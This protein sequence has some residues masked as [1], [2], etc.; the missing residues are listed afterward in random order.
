GDG[1]GALGLGGE[2]AGD[3]LRAVLAGQDPDGVRLGRASR[4]V[5]GF[6]LTF[7]APKSVSLLWA[8]GDPNIAAEVAAAHDAAVADTVGYLE[9]HAC[10]TR[11]GPQG[12]QRV[13]GEGFV[14][15]AFRHR[16]N[17]NGD[18]LLHTHVLIANVVRAGGRWGT[19]DGRLLY[20]EAKTGTY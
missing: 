18:P 3:D 17:R 8:L 14:A 10:A 5:P 9:R 11:R 6:D 16:T 19:L 15:A 2:V 12:V 13:A 7:R 1:V 4:R 20:L